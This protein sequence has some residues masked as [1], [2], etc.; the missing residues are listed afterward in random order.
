MMKWTMFAINTLNV[1]NSENVLLFNTLN[2][3]IL[4][5]NRNVFEAISQCDVEKLKELCTEMH[6]P[7]IYEQLCKQ[8]FLVDDALNEEAEFI[9]IVKTQWEADD[10][11]NVHI[12]PTLGCNFVCPYCYQDGICRNSNL[13]KED[14]DEIILRLQEYLDKN[15]QIS[16]LLVTLHGGEPTCNWDIVPYTMESL[17]L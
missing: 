9:K 13:S 5:F 8:G 3:S 4:G 14:V 12:L 16:F 15:Q 10:R 2:K 17:K 6:Q 11:L 7:E 1:E